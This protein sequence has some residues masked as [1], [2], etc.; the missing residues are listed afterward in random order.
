MCFTKTATTNQNQSGTQSGTQ[1]GVSSSSALDP[2]VRSAYG[3]LLPKAT[4]LSNQPLQLYQGQMVAPLT[5]TQNEGIS[6]IEGASQAA[7]PWLNQAA[8]YA[9]SSATPISLQQFSPSAINQYMSPYT[10]QVV[11]ATQALQNEQDKEQQLNLQ[12]NITAAGAWNGDRAPI[13][14][15]VLARQQSLADN[16]N[17][18]NVL[19]QGYQSAVNQFNTG[20]QTSLQQQQLNN[21]N[22]A[23]AAYSLGSL[24]TA[25][26]NA[27][28]AGGSALINAGGLQQNV[29]QQQLNVPYQQYLQQQ[30][31]PYQSLSY[32]AG[33]L[34]TIAQGTGV[35]TTSN[36]TYSGNN[37]SLGTGSNTQPFSI[38]HTGGRARL[39]DGGANSTD[40]DGSF[41]GS[42]GALPTSALTLLEAQNLSRAGENPVPSYGM[43]SVPQVT[44]YIPSATTSGGGLSFPG[45]STSAP[46]SGNTQ[47]MSLSGLS[48]GSG[49]GQGQQGTG[50]AKGVADTT[51]SGF[52]NG[53]TSGQQ[54][55]SGLGGWASGL[56]ADLGS[57]LFGPSAASVI[58]PDIAGDAAAG[59]LA[60]LGDAAS[61]F[62][63]LAFLK[64]GGRAR[65]ADG[66]N[67]DDDT[68]EI[69]EG[70]S[71][72]LS[73]QPVAVPRGPQTDRAM[74]LQE[75]PLSFRNS[76]NY[77][78]PDAGV[79]DVAG[80]ADNADPSWDD[81]QPVD[82]DA[83]SGTFSSLSPQAQANIATRMGGGLGQPAAQV[84]PPAYKPSPWTA[85]AKGVFSA[86]G[87]HS[88]GQGA[89][90]GIDE[91]EKD[92]HP[93]V[94][95]SGQTQV[96]RYADGTAIDTGVPTEAALNSKATRD[97]R[98]ANMDSIRASRQDATTQ[99]RDAAAANTQAKADALAQRAQEAKDK[100]ADR[101]TQLKIAGMN[102]N[103][104]R[105]TYQAATQP[106][107]NDPTKT[108]PGYLR[109]STR[110][111][112][113]PQ[114]VSGYTPMKGSGAAAGMS[115]R[116][117]VFF[118][119]VTQAGNAATA[120]M[121]NIM[122]LPITIDRGILGGRQQGPGLMDATKE[123]LANA[124]TSQDAQGYNVMLAGVSRNLS[125]I[126][127]SGLAP[128]GSLT[129]S[130]DSLVIKP[131]DTQD[132]KLRKMAEMRQ[133]VETGLEPQ[134]SN[135]KLPDEQ[136]ALVRRIIGQAQKA[137]PFTQHDIT[138]LESNK[139]PSTTINDVMKQRGL[140]GGNAPAMPKSLPSGSQYSPS[141]KQWRDPKGKIYD[142]SGQPVQ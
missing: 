85:I 126:E 90:A 120:A 11:D 56:G 57:S 136:K 40:S 10:S 59:S 125:A 4:S 60:G 115:G 34:P 9:N 82:P 103:Q 51:G 73:D 35:G 104:G 98:F 117:G 23:G 58:A 141:R 118:N 50:I 53:L 63:S 74:T 37:L 64:K 2:N 84:M 97:Y 41:P 105:Y 7:Q 33:L 46:P 54:S 69:L 99:R 119:R 21:Q 110:G 3:D 8:G 86:L 93:E 49:Q 92:N 27:G 72:S 30:A 137:V 47:P 129:H 111:D 87:H 107:P 106:D 100:E 91:W 62:L 138:M 17:L 26:Q 16:A 24:G 68:T 124:V 25:A 127:A 6:Q 28:L 116:E 5:G 131:G 19:N 67:D 78:A 128:N 70:P 18:S 130:M 94:D 75:S 95:H 121:S 134:L 32:L 14:Q 43:P 96:L 45:G 29:N 13:A 132:T 77:F 20:N 12:G 109:L 65:L 79:G 112:E 66:G 81:G 48:T 61:S 139:S 135:P 39:S 52:M 22:A 102:A 83:P 89:V 76:A 123:D 1:S 101:Q 114:F 80:M 133:I 108:I 15:S 55:G 140:G 122:E 113:P 42:S 88:I 44:S 71:A 38:L 31:Y 36:N 142:A